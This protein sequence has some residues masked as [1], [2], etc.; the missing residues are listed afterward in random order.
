MFLPSSLRG[1]LPRSVLSSYQ[2]PGV[3]ANVCLTDYHI[4]D[5]LV[6]SYFFKSLRHRGVR[7][8]EPRD[9]KLLQHFVSPPGSIVRFSSE[10]N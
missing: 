8:T 5:V 10:Q 1:M 3:R 6:D 4:V 9:K 2:I 7:P